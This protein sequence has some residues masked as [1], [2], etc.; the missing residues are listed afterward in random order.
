MSTPAAARSD[1]ALSRGE[2]EESLAEATLLV[3]GLVSLATSTTVTMEDSIVWRSV[4]R[5]CGVR[6]AADFAPARRRLYASR[7]TLHPP[8][9][10]SGTDVVFP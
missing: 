3:A 10:P 9:R 1:S 8:L 5:D 4:V 7:L 2:L 6:R